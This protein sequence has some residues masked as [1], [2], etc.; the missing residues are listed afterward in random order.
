MG[1]T[2]TDLEVSHILCYVCWEFFGRL[3]DLIKSTKGKA[4]FHSKWHISEYFS[5]WLC[6]FGSNIKLTE[7]TGEVD[8]SLQ[9]TFPSSILFVPN[10]VFN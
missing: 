8:H 9:L 4:C 5:I 3:F 1:F 6:G 2:N 10:T 7:E